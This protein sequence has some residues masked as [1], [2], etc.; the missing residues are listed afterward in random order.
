MVG[1]KSFE[2]ASAYGSGAGNIYNRAQATLR[3]ASDRTPIGTS[4]R[5]GADREKAASPGAGSAAALTLMHGI[6]SGYNP[7]KYLRYWRERKR[8]S[9]SVPSCISGAG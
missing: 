5:A 7:Y 1:H 9:V 3:C 4:T 2:S 8:K 6:I